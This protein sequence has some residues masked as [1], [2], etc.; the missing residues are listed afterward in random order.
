[1]VRLSGENT[2]PVKNHKYLALHDFFV[3][4]KPKSN[5]CTAL[6]TRN[7]TG[8][9]CIIWHAQ[10]TTALQVSVFLTGTPR[11]MVT[12][13]GRSPLPSAN[14]SQDQLWNTLFFYFVQWPNKSTTEKLLHCSYTFRHY[15]VIFRELVVST[16]LSY[17][18]MSMQSLVI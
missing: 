16:L 6:T 12:N 8:N 17:T 3:Y 13:K 2:D 10:N 5:L 9:D 1:M 14:H 15:C 4:N 18:S 11:L 7:T